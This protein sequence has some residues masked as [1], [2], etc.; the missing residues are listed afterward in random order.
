[1]GLMLIGL[2]GLVLLRLRRLRRAS[3]Q[4]TGQ[5]TT[6]MAL[7]LCL[8]LTACTSPDDDA[9]VVAKEAPV[10]TGSANTPAV[11]DTDSLAAL[12]QDDEVSTSAGLP[13]PQSTLATTLP[14]NTLT[15]RSV[16][17]DDRVLKVLADET[18]PETMTKRGP[19]PAA[20]TKSVIDTQAGPVTDTV[21]DITEPATP[22]SIT[23]DAGL[24]ADTVEP[25]GD[26]NAI[27]TADEILV[28][29]GSVTQ[30]TLTANA[31]GVMSTGDAPDNTDKTDAKDNTSNPDNSGNS[32]SSV[33]TDTPLIAN[34]ASD[35]GDEIH[36]FI[37]ASAGH[38]KVIDTLLIPSNSDIEDISI[39]NQGSSYTIGGGIH[40]QRFS[41]ILS[42]TNLGEAGA[43]ISGTTLNRDSFEQSLLDTAPKLVDGVS[44]ET[45]YTLW[46]NDRVTAAVGVGLLAWSLDD[47]SQLQ[48]GTIR[49]EEQGVDVFYQANLAYGLNARMH[50]TLKVT[51]YQ[52]AL[53]KVNNVSV[54]LQ[55]HF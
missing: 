15:A 25:A 54:G 48:N 29:D 24:I 16:S 42:Y 32:D 2:V 5:L 10:A 21:I 13:L 14:L 40:Y 7:M 30:K 34:S 33:T 20:E 28:T 6:A 19:E 35:V 8:T 27:R 3:Q 18:V 39:D 51:R 1:M 4:A 36:W 46:S 37:T 50:V 45:Q 49:D 41:F 55:Y 23:V 12:P 9:V 38:S 11:V 17:D 52:L 43:E 22:K 47:S 44:V 53:N 26:I 31:L